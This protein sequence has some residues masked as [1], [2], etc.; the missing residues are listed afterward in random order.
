MI[1]LRWF[2]RSPG[3]IFTLMAVTCWGL[4]GASVYLEKTNLFL[5]PCP[6]C[7][8]QRIL[9]ILLGTTAV[10]AAIST[11]LS[12]KSIR[13]FALINLLL[14]GVGLYTAGKQTLMQWDPISSLAQSCGK[15]DDFYTMVE[16][17]SFLELLPA[18]F[19]GKGD[20]SV[21][22]WTLAGLSMAN[23]SFIAFS[24]CI[25]GMILMFWKGGRKA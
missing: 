25:I 20:C 14:A 16:S 7:I 19:E 5:E 8:F 4:V 13:F 6:M 24:C 17:S 9:Y 11:Q 2:E 3:M 1:L 23:W 22:D 10:I 21:V 12:K 15:G 18:I